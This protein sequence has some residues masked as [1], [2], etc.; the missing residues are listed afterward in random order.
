MSIR[1]KDSEP[2]T[3]VIN[4]DSAT[5]RWAHMREQLQ[6]A[7]LDYQRV[8]GVDGSLLQ[9]PHRDFSEPAYRHLH[10]RRWAPKELGCYLNHI[11]ALHFFLDSDAKYGLI[12][13]DDVWLDPEIKH[14]LEAAMAHRAHWNMLRKYCQFREVVASAAVGKAEPSSVPY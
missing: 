12:L 10:G 1:G 4:L 11:K 6:S 5:D 7:G 3:L 13:E 14:V 9:R 2:I 8:P